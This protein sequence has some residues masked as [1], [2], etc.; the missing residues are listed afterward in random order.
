MRAGQSQHVD[1]NDEMDHLGLYIAQNN[2]SQHA[3]DLKGD[4]L[5]RLS[6]HGFRTPIDDYFSAVAHGDLPTLPR[7]AMPPR[8]REIVEFLAKS[9]E[10]HRSELASFLL[11]AAGDFRDTFATAIDQA[12]HENKELHRARPLSI[13][14]GMAMTLYVWSP[15]APRLGLPAEQHA[16]TVMVANNEASRRLIELEYTDD[17]VLTGA[18]MRHVSLA[19]L[20]HA[21]L[22]RIKAAA[23]SLQTQRVRQAQAK[24]KIGR[25][26]QCPCGSGKK[27]KRCHGRGP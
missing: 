22:D 13:Y 15:S 4:K 27:F 11:D 19:G 26:E 25:N 3:A 7:Q 6:F 16:R 20:G 5:D 9:T 8:Y 21:E 1:L 14:G 2:Y 12:L 24:G 23:L 10:P 18:H 17:G